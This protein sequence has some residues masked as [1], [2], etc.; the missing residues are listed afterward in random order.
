MWL[1]AVISR[2]A[3]GEHAINLDTIANRVTRAR[4]LG[5]LRRTDRLRVEVPGPSW[6]RPGPGRTRR[7]SASGFAVVSSGS[8]AGTVSMYRTADYG[9]EEPMFDPL[10]AEFDSDE[11]ARLR[12]EA[13]QPHP[14]RELV[15]GLASM[16]CWPPPRTPTPLSPAFESPE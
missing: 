10:T 11:L 1:S 2:V 9:Q 15:P 14:V 13:R 16:T 5:H 4:P 12:P 8:H 3:E 7:R 6:S